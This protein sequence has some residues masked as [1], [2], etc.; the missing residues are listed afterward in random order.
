MK[1]LALFLLFV[2]VSLPSVCTAQMTAKVA[3]TMPLTELAHLLLGK[4]GAIMIGIDRPRFP[5]ILEPIR[6]YSHAIVTGSQ[7]GLC[8]SDWVTV[9]F[10]EKGNVERLSS[11]RRFGVA[12]NIYRAPGSWTYDEYGQLC[13]AVKSTKNYFPAP[14]GQAALE[15]A[16][17]VD[18][19]TGKG[20]YAQQHFSYS[21][22][23][24]CSKNRIDLKWLRLGNIDAA[25]EIDCPAT[26]LKLP[27]CYEVTVGD[28]K[29]GAF[30][31]IYKIYGS[32]YM[33]KVVVWA[34]SVDVSFTLE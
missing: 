11:Q 17:Y 21:C 34:V 22:T 29:I 23:G 7:F 4:S 30:P 19:I 18:A 5:G 25:R 10:D 33:N 3:R 1:K 20:P 6:F 28:A 16:W 12:G 13:S 15:I 31:K 2:S 14:S 32:C 26:K 9:G 24:S 27:S 8:G